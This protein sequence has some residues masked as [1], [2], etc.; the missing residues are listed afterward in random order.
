MFK[1]PKSIVFYQN[2]LRQCKKNLYSNM[3][4]PV[5]KRDTKQEGDTENSKLKFDKKL[6]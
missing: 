1:L 4:I 2:F 6:Y 3:K 5:F